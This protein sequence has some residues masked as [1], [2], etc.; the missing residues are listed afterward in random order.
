[1]I[2]RSSAAM[3]WMPL[4]AAGFGVGFLANCS[5]VSSNPLADTPGRGGA[6]AG[7]ES[8]S[9]GEAMGGSPWNGAG[10][11]SAGGSG[12]AG[13]MQ[14]GAAGSDAGSNAGNGGAAGEGGEAGESTQ[15]GAA[16]DASSAGHHGGDSGSGG[17]TSEGG[18]SGEGGSANAAGSG[19]SGG[20]SNFDPV[21]LEAMVY[22][23]SADVGLTEADG[24][25]TEWLDRSGNQGDAR[26]LLAGSRPKLGTFAGTELPAVVF[27]GQDDY[28]AMS[29]LAANF[30][31]GLTF[32]AVARATAEGLCMSMLEASNGS[33]IE[34]FAFFLLREGLA[35]EVGDFTSQGQEGA[36]A[37]GEPRLLDVTHTPDRVVSLFLNGFATATSAFA[38]PVTTTRNQNFIGRSLYRDCTTWSGELAEILLYAR[39]LPSEERQAIR[40]Y[41]DE[42]WGCCADSAGAPSAA[43]FDGASD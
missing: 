18:A 29:P 30:E 5:G 42:K 37:V 43:A 26:Q 16:G 38:L 34:E 32:F 13:D 25:I 27:D 33:E 20:T 17:M 9:A 23:F 35:Y 31:A 11:S 1:M 3:R 7:T 22:W 24:T 39:P 19:N 2:E 10:S 8:A 28:L 4:M 21:S 40:R 41:L 15:G 6:S 36:F 14:A 12:I